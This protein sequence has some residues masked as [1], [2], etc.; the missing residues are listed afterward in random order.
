MSHRI[1]RIATPRPN[2]EPN[3]AQSVIL[4]T[5]KFPS[6]TSTK[7]LEQVYSGMAHSF[8]SRGPRNA[9]YA[10]GYQLLEVSGRA[11]WLRFAFHAEPSHSPKPQLVQCAKCLK[12]DHATS[13]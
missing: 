4:L 3:P 11:S 13:N 8:Q 10:G 9:T 7:R 12:F 1:T 5:S 6:K 2:H